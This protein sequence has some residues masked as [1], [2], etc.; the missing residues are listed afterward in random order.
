MSDPNHS[1]D[2]VGELERFRGRQDADGAVQTR[3]PV[4]A[5]DLTGNEEAYV[6][7]A[8]RSSWISST[9]P[10]LDRFEREFGLLGGARSSVGLCNGTVALPLALLALEVRP[11]VAAR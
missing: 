8:I 1:R 9:G 3:I 10:F 6:V 11:G 2:A 4:A 7:E 5:P